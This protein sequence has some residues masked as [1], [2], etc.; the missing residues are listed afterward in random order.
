[1][2][3]KLL[4]GIMLVGFMVGSVGA[5]TITENLDTMDSN[6]KQANDLLIGLNVLSDTYKS[7]VRTNAMIQA[8]VDGGQFDQI[9]LNVKQ[10][11]N[12]SWIALKNYITAIEGNP[13]IME[14]FAHGQ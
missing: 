11:L 8:L 1:M 10:A 14:A 5:Q 9:P 4:L 2:F 6:L 13:D 3:K 12:Q 7:A